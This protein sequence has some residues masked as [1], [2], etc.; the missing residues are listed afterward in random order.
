MTNVHETKACICNNNQTNLVTRSHK[1]SYKVT[2]KIKRYL[3]KTSQWVILQAISFSA[4]S[5][6]STKRKL[7][8]KKEKK[9][10]QKKMTKKQQQQKPWW[11][12]CVS[13]NSK[14]DFQMTKCLQLQGALS[15]G[16]HEGLCPS[17]QPGTFSLKLMIPSG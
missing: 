13:E 12:F 10:D 4:I 1:K 11:F 7:K 9:K 5:R 6:I 8:K 15:P 17:T 3:E 2:G 16:P 14:F